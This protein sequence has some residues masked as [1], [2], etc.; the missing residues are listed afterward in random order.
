V[1]QS[2]LL[3][4]NVYASIAGLLSFCPVV[5][6]FHGGVD[7]ST[8]ERFQW[9]KY[10]A[11]NLG[12]RKIIAVS[13][14]LKQELLER[15]I[16]NKNKMAVI[17]NGIDV[18]KFDLPVSARIRKLYG[19][20]DKEIIIG[21]LGNIRPAKGYDILLQAAAKLKLQS[22]NIRFVIAGQGK[23]SL[24]HE[25]YDLQK[26][27]DVEDSV[28][29]VGFC[30]EP[31]EFLSN[32]D[33][34]LLSSISE[35]FSIA[36]IQAMA[37][38]RPVIATKCGG[39]EEIIQDGVTGVLIE[40]NNPDAIVESI[41]QL[42]QNPEVCEELVNNANKEFQQRFDMEGMLRSYRNIYDDL[43]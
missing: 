11:I 7:I 22:S 16:L 38:G 39:P 6:V 42:Q 8:K 23:T 28:K 37:A 4:S 10:T 29:F 41:Q 25:L 14:S 19:W 20:T 24:E 5:S 15:T 27:L 35:G 43:R 9:F 34:F 31:E 2:H 30:Q 18:K 36:T 21:C 1:I 32:I 26:Q 3:G 13:E 12:S 33:I 17:Y 40:K